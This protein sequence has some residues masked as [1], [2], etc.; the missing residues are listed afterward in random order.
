MILY[1]GVRRIERGTGRRRPALMLVARTQYVVTLALIPLTMLLFAQVSLVSPIANA[2]A[3][4]LISFV[5]R[6][7]A[8]AGS[9]LP[10]PL[11][12]ALLGI[13]HFGAEVLAIFPK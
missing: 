7:L 1:A 2:R 9:M 11:S 13:A 8:L 4:P 5:V 6:P 3:I 10:A 12:D